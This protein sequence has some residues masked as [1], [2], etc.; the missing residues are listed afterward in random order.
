MAHTQ[1]MLASH[2]AAGHGSYSLYAFSAVPHMHCSRLQRSN[3]T[4]TSPLLLQPHRPCTHH[5]QRQLK[6]AAAGNERGTVTTVVSFQKADSAG[7]GGGA[8]AIEAAGS[9]QQQQSWVWEDSDDGAA[10]Y[11]AFFLWLALGSWP[12]LQ[13]LNIAGQS[14]SLTQVHLCMTL[15][16]RG[17]LQQ[18]Q[19]QAVC[20]RLASRA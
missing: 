4:Q 9:D 13:S 10:A 19:Q 14:V 5:R 1:G 15:G 7:P 8:A 12:A 3:S 2:R 6:P 11:A 20:N 16:Q 18:Q 17:C